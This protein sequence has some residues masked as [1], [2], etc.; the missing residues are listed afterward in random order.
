MPKKCNSGR[1]T[2]R[3]LER[4]EQQNFQAPPDKPQLFF[5]EA[6][7]RAAHTAHSTAYNSTKHLLLFLFALQAFSSQPL[8]LL[9]NFWSNF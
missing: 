3:A 2:H 8:R 1:S 9:L 7:A 6:K 5:V 4:L